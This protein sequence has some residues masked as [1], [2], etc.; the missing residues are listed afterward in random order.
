MDIIFECPICLEEI[1]DAV[2]GSCTHHYCFYCLYSHCKKNNKC[3]L[4]KNKIRE[5]RFDY[6]FQNL[7]NQ[8]NNT[9]NNNN[10]NINEIIIKKEFINNFKNCKEINLINNQNKIA[11]IT[12]KNNIGP[13]VKIINLKKNSIF[14]EYFKIYDVL[15][16]INK[17]PCINHTDVIEQINYLF[18]NNLDIKIIKL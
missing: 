2:I 6:Q 18:A 17:V 11:G 4:C 13:G 12:I 3:P 9:L 16:F 10:N 7:I 15:L 1:T 14:N 8:F 5:I